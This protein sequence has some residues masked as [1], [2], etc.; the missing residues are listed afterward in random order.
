M[1]IK[2]STVPAL[3]RAL[4]IIEY[5]AAQDEP[6]ALKE[7]AEAMGI[8]ISSAFRLVKNL[9]NRGYVQ[10]MSGGQA[11]YC[12]GEQIVVLAMSREK[13]DSLRGKAQPVM[14]DL[15]AEV[16]Q[17]VQLAVM[18]N[19]TLLYIAQTLSNVPGAIS[20]VAPMYTPLNIHTSAAGKLLFGDL[21][22]E[23]QSTCLEHMDFTPSTPNTITSP[24]AFQAEARRSW[25]RGY[26]IDDEE[27]AIGLGCM[28]VPV[29]CREVCIAAL[30][31]TGPISQ[32][33]NQERFNFLLHTLQK[34]AVRLSDS[35]FF[36]QQHE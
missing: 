14:D 25:E 8:P 19:E 11:T 6:I 29:F 18:K 2:N 3:E 26:G 35:M 13:G 20:V 31:I 21:P 27:Y 7:L 9:V 5:L 1:E 10:E 4:N 23:R 33:R 22:P 24:K 16:G 34:S 12:L 36:Y 17:T 30:G 32:Y 28:A 15:S